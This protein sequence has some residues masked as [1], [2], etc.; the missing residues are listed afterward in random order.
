MDVLAL[1]FG[2]ALA[3]LIQAMTLWTASLLTGFGSQMRLVQTNTPITST[4]QWGS[5][6]EANYSGYAPIAISAYEAPG[7]DPAGNVYSNGGLQVFANNGGGTGNIIYSAVI[8]AQ[9]PGSTQATGTVTTGAG[10]VSAPVIT[11][12][13]AGYLVPPKVTVLGGGTGA[14]ITA[15]ITAGAVTALT[16]VSGGT[17]YTSATIVIEPPLQIVAFQNFPTPVP[18]NVATD[19]LPLIAQ[20]NFS[21]T[22]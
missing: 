11:L 17:G 22:P 20:V 4:T 2:K 3:A 7:I 16:L 10:V 18:L 5:P 14:V 9:I 12:A 8:V 15:T 1:T 6:V 19:K 13:G 21:S